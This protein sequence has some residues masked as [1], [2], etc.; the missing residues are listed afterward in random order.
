MVLPGTELWRKAEGLRLEFDPEPPYYVRSHFSMSAADIEYGQ[1][2]IAAVDRMKNSPTI[3]LL[4]RE[5]DLTFADLVDEWIE[6]QPTRSGANST[7]DE[8]QQF[9]LHVCDK[10]RIPSTFYR[11]AATIEVG[12]PRSRPAV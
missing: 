5:P 1:R 7:E 9:V 8:I 3:R 2:L 11:A 4:A 6:W 12:G 10:K